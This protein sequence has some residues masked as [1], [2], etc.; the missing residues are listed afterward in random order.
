MRVFWI[1]PQACSRLIDKSGPHLE[2]CLRYHIYSR[3]NSSPLPP[4]HKKSIQYI[5]NM[6]Q[7]FGDQPRL[8]HRQ[9]RSIP[10]HQSLFSYFSGIASQCSGIWCRSTFEAW[11]WA[12][13][14]LKNGCR[15]TFKPV[16][17]R[18]SQV[19]RWWLKWWWFNREG[20]SVLL[21]AGVVGAT[22]PV[23]LVS[24]AVL[25]VF[26]TSFYG[27]VSKRKAGLNIS[28]ASNL[29]GE[30]CKLLNLFSS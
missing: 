22:V 24:V 7:P 29:R 19:R 20:R 30:R 17:L 13:A 18:G 1:G 26:F 28:L 5:S 3:F 21:I 12:W 16:D 23:L 9:Q 8:A 25:P 10:S 2:V 6:L 27:T 4:P 11:A 14:T 15:P